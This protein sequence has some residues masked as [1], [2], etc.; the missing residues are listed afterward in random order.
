[1]GRQAAIRKSAPFLLVLLVLTGLYLISLRNYLLFHSV[2]EVFSIVVAGTIFVVAWNSRQWMDNNYL[3][4]IGIAVLFTGGIDLVHTLAYRGVG[5]FSGYDSNLATQLWIA[6]RYT[7]AV[8]FL[9]APLF[10]NRKLRVNLAFLCFALVTIL[11]LTSIFYWK[12]FPACYV[13][14]TGLTAF[15]KVSEYIISAIFLASV[16]LLFRKRA[17]FDKSVFYLL[18]VSIVLTAGAELAFTTYLSVF[19]SAVAFG[20]ILRV[21]AVYL[22]YKALIETGLTRPYDFLFRNLRDSEEKF[23]TVFMT[24]PDAVYLATLEDGL[25]VEINKGYENVFG[26]TREEAIGKTPLQLN[27]Y[28]N[29]A[30]RARMIS[31]LK[32]KGFVR[33]LELRGRRKNGAIFTGLLS[34]SP[35]TIENRQHTVGIIRDITERKQAEDALREN[36]EKYRILFESSIEGIGYSKGNSIVHANRAL[37]EIFGYVSLEEYVSKPLIDHVAPESKAFILDRVAKRE[38]NEYMPPRYECRIVRKDGAIRDVEIST[39]IVSLGGENFVQSTFKDVTDHNRAEHALR[40]SEERYRS[41]FEKSL[42]A[43]FLLDSATGRY[44]D[45][46]S[47]AQTLT[48]RTV[49]SLRRLTTADVTPAG[50]GNRLQIAR[51]V[52]ESRDIGEVEF[53]RPDGSKRTALMSIVPAGGNLVF[54]IALDI[55]TRKERRMLEA[56]L[57]SMSEGLVVLDSDRRVAYFNHVA[58]TLVGVNARDILGQSAEV[59]HSIVSSRASD[60]V[61]LLAAWADALKRLEELPRFESE[62]VTSLGKRV[63]EATMFMVGDKENPL[64]S[65]T[66]L[67]DVT[68]E[69][70]IDRMKSEF[71][72]IASHELRTPLTGIYGFAEL[73]LKRAPELTEGHRKWAQTV[74][75]ESARL[76]SIV[77]DL[78]NVSSIEAGR[79]SLDLGP[80][81]ARPVVERVIEHA[82]YAYSSH[83]INVEIPDAFPMVL[84][85]GEKLQQVFHNLIDN[86]CKYSPGGGPVVVSV[87]VDLGKEMSVFSVS[88]KGLGIPEDEI[89]K[90]FTRFHRVLRPEMT[91]LRGT[92]LGLYIVK[93]LVEM[94]GGNIRVESKVNQGSTFFFSLPLAELLSE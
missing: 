87:K 74:H 63:V 43:I 37:L 57:G 92:G 33:E 68:R 75:T 22:I 6:A 24:S 19:G 54:G 67:R 88:D 55:T 80:V 73:L 34:V 58:E 14:G 50:A 39:S 61:A 15:K 36:E 9:I 11:L 45:A 59:L 7:Q 25:I 85:D 26:Y 66:I 35:V 84:A 47:A 44:V 21:A 30:D 69:R 52:T 79:L 48:G 17:S 10:L 81:E 89:P 65:G 78:L 71:V 31:E 64:G 77:E 29:A 18:V 16:F 1:M 51:T 90:L 40:E 27:L 53:V 91:G 23:R 38:R 70:E 12:I 72:S 62:V 32:T 5:V 2:A 46:N 13:E 49:E 86:A 41:I 42:N 56:I 20:H 83:Q 82:R 93:S 94:M 3:L 60:P 28:E 76:S 4:F 8:S